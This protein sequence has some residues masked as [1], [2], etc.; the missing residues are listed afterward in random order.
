M[1]HGLITN[2]GLDMI[3]Y[4]RVQFS[5]LKQTRLS[6]KLTQLKFF[7]PSQ[8]KSRGSTKF[9]IQKLRQIGQWIP[10]L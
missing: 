1:V 8:D 10:K 2:F 7:K 9:P 3:K 6:S 5:S 4:I